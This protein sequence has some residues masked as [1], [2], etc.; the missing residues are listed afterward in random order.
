ME[1]LKVIAAERRRHILALVWDR[2]RTAGDIASHFD[3]SWPAI[4]QHL[5]ILREA[6]YV[7]QRREGTTLYYRANPGAL[8]ELRSIVESHWRSGLDRLKTMV[9]QRAAEAGRPRRLVESDKEKP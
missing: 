2:E 6:G 7:T 5:K 9:E 8:G 4:S 1:P 3:V